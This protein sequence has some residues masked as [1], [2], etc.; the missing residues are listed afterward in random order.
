MGGPLGKTK[1]GSPNGI[2]E[3]SNAMRAFTVVCA[4]SQEAAA[5]LFE[6]HPHFTHFPGNSVEMKARPARASDRTKLFHRG[7]VFVALVSLTIKGSVA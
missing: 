2:E 1:K 5:K 3:I 7:F 6:D 4:E